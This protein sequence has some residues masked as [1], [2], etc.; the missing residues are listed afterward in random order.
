MAVNKPKISPLA[1]RIEAQ[2]VVKGLTQ[3]DLVRSSG[4]SQSMLNHLRGGR[5]AL[6]DCIKIFNLAD[7]LGCD[8]RWLAT[9]ENKK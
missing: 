8:A 7:S 3:A 4:I 5:V 6:V 2:L 1:Q 9:G